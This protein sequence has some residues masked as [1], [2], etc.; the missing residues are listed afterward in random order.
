[1]GYGVWW[2]DLNKERIE[3]FLFNLDEYREKL[4]SYPA[5]D[6][7][8]IFTKLDELVAGF[9]GHSAHRSATAR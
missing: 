3:S 5:Q 6:N 4:A 1:M 2:D 8:R 9:A 7:S